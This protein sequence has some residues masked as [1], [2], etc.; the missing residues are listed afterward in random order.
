MKPEK[1]IFHFKNWL[2][3]RSI[4]LNYNLSPYQIV[5]YYLLKINV[6]KNSGKINIKKADKQIPRKIDKTSEPCELFIKKDAARRAIPL[7]ARYHNSTFQSIEKIF[8]KMLFICR[9]RNKRIF[10]VVLPFSKIYNLGIGDKWKSDF[11]LKLDHY[12]TKYDLLVLDYSR[13]ARFENDC[14]LFL[15]ADHLNMKG[16]VKFTKILLEDLKDK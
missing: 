11:D 10:L 1:N 12:Q 5:K 14:T 3:D 8:R 7:Q 16:A 2:Y 9:K 6:N 15:N 13:D 4:L